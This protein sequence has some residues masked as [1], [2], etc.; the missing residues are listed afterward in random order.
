MPNWFFL[1]G[2]SLGIDRPIQW[3]RFPVENL[4]TIAD[5]RSTIAIKLLD[6]NTFLQI[7]F[8]LYNLAYRR[9]GAGRW[10]NA[11][12]STALQGFY[13]LPGEYED[14]DY[15]VELSIISS[16]STLSTP[17]VRFIVKAEIGRRSMLLW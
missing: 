5:N 11:S 12:F 9:V 6:F 10:L 16:G 14:G 1:L 13:T 7:V 2:I 8:P 4:T 17:A 3:L 15:E